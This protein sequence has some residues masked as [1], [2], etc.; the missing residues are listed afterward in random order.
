MLELT[1]NATTAHNSFENYEKLISTDEGVEFFIQII[2]FAMAIKKTYI[3]PFPRLGT[4]LAN[5]GDS[6]IHWMNINGKCIQLFSNL[7]MT[8]FFNNDICLHELIIAASY[9]LNQNIDPTFLRRKQKCSALSFSKISSDLTKLKSPCVENNANPCCSLYQNVTIDDHLETFLEILK[10]SYITNFINEEEKRNFLNKFV[11]KVLGNQSL[12]YIDSPQTTLNT[13]LFS[14]FAYDLNNINSQR[15]KLWPVVTGNGLC[16]SYNS[17]PPHLIY[18][19][20]YYQ[21]I[22]NSTFGVKHDAKLEYPTA[23]GPSQ[24]LFIVVQSF[25]PS[26]ARASQEFMLSF[27]NEFNPYD[28]IKESFKIMPG[29]EHTFRIIPSQISTTKRFDE[30][31]L[32]D[33]KCQLKHE[34]NGMKLMLSYSKSGCEFE[35]AIQKASEACHC[36]PWLMPRKVVNFKTCDMLGNL[37]FKNTFNSP[38]IYGDCN[39][40]NDCQTTRY[41]IS[42]SSRPIANWRQLCSD[43]KLID[44]FYQFIKENY[45]LFLIYKKGINPEILENVCEFVIQNHI[46]VIEVKIGAKSVIKSVRD[47]KITFE[48]QLSA[49][50]IIV[51]LYIKTK[52]KFLILMMNFKSNFNLNLYNFDNDS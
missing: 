12:D 27:T 19:N 13:I 45:K 5:V 52:L 11:K 43:N 1:R 31:K 8:L 50:G 37:C 4:T 33:R 47:V 9:N 3:R 34:N 7:T 20:S 17:L 18:Q 21:G 44:T 22:W 30:M 49:I 51:V 32:S 2:Q 39:C 10:H 24:P 36:L 46:S 28:V 15:N 48:N 14:D 26:L 16:Y 23:S 6:I 41:A 40:A 38:E 35:C 25:E 42:E 29:Y